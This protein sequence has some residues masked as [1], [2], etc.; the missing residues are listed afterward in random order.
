MPRSF[1][2]RACRAVALAAT[3]CLAA[4][5][6]VQPTEPPASACTRLAAKTIPA[7]AIGLPS[8]DAS[9]SEA[10]LVAD[11]PQTISVGAATPALPQHCKVTGSIAPR[12]PGAQRIHFQL[13]LPTRWNG[14][15]LQYGGG[16]SMACP[17]PGLRRCATPR[18]ATRCP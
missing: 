13:N 6:S 1:P 12:G 8:G 11:A 14:Q 16:N 9:V 7:V 18:R 15:A 17:S 10:V 4:C 5:S 2:R 3:V